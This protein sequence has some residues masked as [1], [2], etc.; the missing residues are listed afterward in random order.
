M[1][2]RPFLSSSTP[3]TGSSRAR[4][5]S[6]APPSR[7]TRAL[8]FAYGRMRFFGDWDGELRFPPYDP[9]ALLY[10]HTIGLSALARQEVFRRRAA[11]TRPSSSS[12][13]GSTGYNALAFGWEG[14][15]GGRGHG[16]VPAPRRI[17][18]VGRPGLLPRHLSPP[19][20]E[21][22]ASSIAASA[23]T[24]LGPLGRAWYRWFW[25]FRPI[26]SRLELR[27]HRLR[28]RAKEAAGNRR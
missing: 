4:S 13:T 24:R 6:F 20:R 12:R 19:P 16:R 9:Y 22:Q 27:L 2:R 5:A 28:W 15:A 17:Q 10:R 11:S 18:A 1:C 8:G 14:Q 21:A 23:R 3:T 26:P 7:P 25:G